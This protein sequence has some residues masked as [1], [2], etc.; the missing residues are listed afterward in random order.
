VKV[1][2]ISE[3]LQLAEGYVVVVVVVVVGG[4]A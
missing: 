4:G 3:D 1:R 2:L